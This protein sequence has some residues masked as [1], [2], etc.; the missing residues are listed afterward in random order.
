MKITFKWADKTQHFCC[1]KL[2]TENV[3]GCTFQCNSNYCSCGS[4]MNRTNILQVHR[5]HTI[6]SPKF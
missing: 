2:S 3:N 4:W 6:I 1:T 5:W